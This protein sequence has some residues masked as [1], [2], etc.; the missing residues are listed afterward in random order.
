LQ[1]IGFLAILSLSSIDRVNI[2]KYYENNVHFLV[3]AIATVTFGTL[4]HIT[5]GASHEQ[6]HHKVRFECE[7]ITQ[8]AQAGACSS[9][10]ARRRGLRL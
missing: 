9:K 3:H 1:I 5:K 8:S 7:K 6:D 4:H 2:C 10:P